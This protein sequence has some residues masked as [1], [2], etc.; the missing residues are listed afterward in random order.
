MELAGRRPD[1]FVAGGGEGVLDAARRAAGAKPIV[2][3]FIDFDPVARGHIASLA[4]PG[5]NVT[6]LYLQQTDLAAKKLELLEEA[7]PSAKR[8]AVLFEN[9][10]REQQHIAQSAAKALG[11]TLLPQELRGQPYDYDGALR[12]AAGDK[13]DAVL[14]LS[15]GAFFVGVSS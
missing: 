12:V 9:S 14:M 2:M 8:I 3:L 13:A 6:G 4:R 7:V 1:V 5:G 15:S 11:V 10:T